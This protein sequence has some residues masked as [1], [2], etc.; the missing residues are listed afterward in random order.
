VYFYFE[1]YSG[2][3]DKIS[4]FCALTNEILKNRKNDPA[5]HINQISPQNVKIPIKISRISLVAK[6]KVSHVYE[7]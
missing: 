7:A 4:D 5:F 2:H 3:I 1:L 6:L